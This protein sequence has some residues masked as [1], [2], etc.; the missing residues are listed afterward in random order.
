MIPKGV[1]VSIKSRTVEV[2]G[3]YGTLK[4]DFSHV[5]LHIRKID[6]GKK[7][8]AELWLGTRV[9]MMCV[10]SVVSHIRNMMKGVMRKYQYKMR[11]AYVH[12]PIQVSILNEGTKVEIRKFLGEQVVK[13]IDLL[14]G[15][16]IVRSADVKD[17]LI[18]EGTD[19][20]NVSRSA[21]LIHQSCLVRNKDI[22]KFLDGIYVSH[23]GMVD[24]E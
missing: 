5:P 1:K 11:L 8:T 6:G 3:K 22:R 12:A 20:E 10:Q 16:T 7:I 19:K 9:P 4:R 14:D 24:N 17:E 21:A 23:M 18:L 2:S 15:V 13:S